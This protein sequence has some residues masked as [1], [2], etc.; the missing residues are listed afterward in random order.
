MYG[1]IGVSVP[2]LHRESTD[3]LIQVVRMVGYAVGEVIRPSSDPSEEVS[4]LEPTRWQPQ[5]N[6]GSCYEV[7]T[8]WVHPRYICAFP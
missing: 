4:E 5:H 3:S 1:S 8:A 6:T 7:V 2:S